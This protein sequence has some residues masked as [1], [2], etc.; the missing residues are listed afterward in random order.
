MQ[1]SRIAL[2]EFHRL[3]FSTGIRG[4][5]LVQAQIIFEAKNKIIKL[6][7][8]KPNIHFSSC[9]NIVQDNASTIHLIVG[10]NHANHSQMILRIVCV[11][12][13]WKTF[14]SQSYLGILSV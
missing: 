12:A 8:Y 13:F 1:P 3:L 9:L 7:V 11:G 4:I 14:S 5:G 10:A 2:R 6:C